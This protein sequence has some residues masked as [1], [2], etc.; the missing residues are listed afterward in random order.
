MKGKYISYYLMILCLIFSCNK[1]NEQ[2]EMTATPEP[3]A[4]QDFAKILS[5]E[6]SGEMKAYQFAVEVESPDTGC[7]QYADWWEVIDEEGNLIYRRILLHS[8]VNEQPFKRSGGPVAVTSDE[9]IIVRAHMNNR[10]YGSQVVIGNVKKGFASIEMQ[11]F[12]FELEK[13]EP[14]PENCDF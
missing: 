8:H 9:T 3:E 10:S 14:L 6:V 2:T 13:I 5:V 11:D 1:S 4:E 7:D 12:A